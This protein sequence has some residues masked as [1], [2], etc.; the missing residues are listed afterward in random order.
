MGL[1]LRLLLAAGGSVAALFVARDSPVFEVAQGIFATI[2][3]VVVL[4][5]LALIPPR[6]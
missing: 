2:V 5:A 4:F 1:L 6:R 3:V